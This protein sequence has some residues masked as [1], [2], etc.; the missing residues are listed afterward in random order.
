MIGCFPRNPF[1]HFCYSCVLRCI[2]NT[3]FHEG[4]GEIIS[5][6]KTGL[7]VSKYSKVIYL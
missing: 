3:L 2:S 4:N 7:R 1:G 6:T 5:P